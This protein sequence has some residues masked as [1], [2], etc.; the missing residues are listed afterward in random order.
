V[1]EYDH[2]RL[3]RDPEAGTAWIV[4]D[5]PDRRNALN[6][7]LVAELK[8]ALRTLDGD[9]EVRVIGLR[10]EGPDFCAGADLREVRATMDEGVLASQADADALGELFVLLRRLRRPVVAAV[11]GRALAGGCGLATACDLIVAAE[12]AEFGYPEVRLGFVPAMVMALLRRSLGEKRAFEL[13]ALGNRFGA[14]RAHELGLVARLLPPGEL[15]EGAR[16][17]AAELAG[18][19]AS[20]VTLTKRLLYGLDGVAFEDA[21]RAG[22]DVNALARLTEDCRAGVDKFL[23][24]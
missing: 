7:S 3:E 15:E 9:G 10:G 18:R 19:S 1:S 17:L 8:H 24:R 5:D 6:A 20:A 21:I 2:I 16:S 4:L 13:A 23:S 12:D 22:A 14:R 11:H